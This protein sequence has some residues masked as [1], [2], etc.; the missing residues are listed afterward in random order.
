MKR[1]LLFFL[2]L[3]FLT[4]SCT[5]ATKPDAAQTESAPK[6]QVKVIHVRQGSISDD[7]TLFATTY[8][9]KRN[10]V[11]APIPAFITGVNVKLGDKVIK[12]DI[13]YILQSKESRALGTEAVKIDSTLSGFGIIKVRAS[14]SGVISTLDKQQPGDYVL[15]GGPLCTIAESSD[16][17][18][19]VNVPFEYATFAKT[20][21]SCTIILPDNKSYPGTFSTALT[22]MNVLAQTQTILAKTKQSLFLPEN[23]IVKVMVS[24][25]SSTGKQVFPKS[26]VLTDEMMSEY[27]VMKLI[28]DST[29]VKVPIQIGNRNS[30][31]VEIIS[32]KFSLSDR[33]ISSGSYG[34]PDTALISISK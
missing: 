10:I 19:M 8:Y 20:G 21:K 30:E 6:A 1:I 27:W 22:A 32:P 14:A 4:D 9:L 12:G 15:E 31:N 26:A 3:P 17:A 16:L 13:L 34:L 25:S 7:L 18:F 11:T 29:A 2:V 28:D 5:P 24:K 23:M 33:I